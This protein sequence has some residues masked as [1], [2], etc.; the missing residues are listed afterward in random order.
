LD[1]T[2]TIERGSRATA[3]ARGGQAFDDDGRGAG[4]AGNEK[5]REQ[6]G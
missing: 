5:K 3:G 1:A 6:G 2:T 4:E